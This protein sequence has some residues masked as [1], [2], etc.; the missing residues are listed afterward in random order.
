MVIGIIGDHWLAA[1]SN[2]AE[3]VAGQVVQGA[4]E[5][6]HANVRCF[7]WERMRVWR[8]FR[9]RLSNHRKLKMKPVLGIVLVLACLVAAAPRISAQAQ[10]ASN[11]PGASQ[12]PP[13]SAQQPSRVQKQSNTNPFP[14]DESTVPVISPGNVPNLPPGENGEAGSRMPDAL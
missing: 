12:N 7:V 8:A 1:A 14:E 5:N 9:L 13:A 2:Q 3:Q 4:D 11:A 6:S 10:P